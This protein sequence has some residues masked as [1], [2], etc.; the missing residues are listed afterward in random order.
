MKK[1]MKKERNIDIDIYLNETLV[2]NRKKY[3]LTLYYNEK[4]I[5]LS[6]RLNNKYF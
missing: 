1:Q 6:F 2:S 5:I 4:T 3:R